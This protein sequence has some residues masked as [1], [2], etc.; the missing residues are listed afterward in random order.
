[1]VASES[2]AELQSRVA[3]LETEIRELRTR[4][5]ALERLIGN[6]GEHATDRTVVQGKVSYDWQA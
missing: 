6:V 3:R 1:M 2:P 5:V 4:L